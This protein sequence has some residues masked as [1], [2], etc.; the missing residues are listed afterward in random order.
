MRTKED[1][2]GKGSHAAGSKASGTASS[3]KKAKVVLS[4]SKSK[5][6]LDAK[7]AVTRAKR[8]SGPAASPGRTSASAQR[9]VSLDSKGSSMRIEKESE[10]GKKMRRPNAAILQ[11]GNGRPNGSR[12][13]VKHAAVRTNGALKRTLPPMPV[14]P[15]KSTPIPHNLAHYTSLVALLDVLEPFC[16]AA[17]YGKGCR[18]AG[19]CGVDGPSLSASS[20]SDAVG[21]LNRLKRLRHQVGRAR[22]RKLSLSALEAPECPSCLFVFVQAVIII[23]RI[24]VVW[25]S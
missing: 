2:A 8:D 3:K 12:F 15:G 20:A 23:I 9:S 25:T 7:T 16:M 22:E 11:R 10:A 4:R 18:P 14:Q 21:A 13:S 5:M 1:V 19:C 6:R 17:G 24:V